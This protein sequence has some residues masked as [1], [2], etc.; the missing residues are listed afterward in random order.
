MNPRGPY[1]LVADDDPDDQEMLAERFQK[2]NPDIRV[3]LVGNA[4]EA[5]SF[6]RD[7]SADELPQLIVVDYKMPILTGYDFLLAVKK[8]PRLQSIPKLVWST[9]NNQEYVDKCMGNGALRYF[10]KPN[11]VRELDL[12]VGEISRIIHL[13]KKPTGA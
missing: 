6:L 3:E 1:I 13:A 10:V 9:S 11:N 2:V 8:D 12:L 4:Q 7:R 5:L